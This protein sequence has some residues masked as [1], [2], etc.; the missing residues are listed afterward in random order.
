M[1]ILTEV[2]N[3]FLFNLEKY[4]NEQDVSEYCKEKS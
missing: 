2:S 3:W 1:G 4:G